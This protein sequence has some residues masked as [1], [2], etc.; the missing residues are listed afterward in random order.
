MASECL[1]EC[2]PPVLK[3][4]P[5]GTANGTAKEANGINWAEAGENAQVAHE[6]VSVVQSR[7]GEVS[8]GKNNGEWEGMP[9]VA[10]LLCR[11]TLSQLLGRLHDGQR[12]SSV[13]CP[14]TFCYRIFCPWPQSR[15]EN[16]QEQEFK[17]TPFKNC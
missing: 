7:V 13:A 16:E 17:L 9:R 1:C 14:I 12:P 10:K 15:V 2:D 8:G 3:R 5:V 6:Y 11:V 4:V